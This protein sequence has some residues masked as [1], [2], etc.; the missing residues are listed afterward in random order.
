MDV[1]AN[2]GRSAASRQSTAA[3]STMYRVRHGSDG[4]RLAMTRPVHGKLRPRAESR[5]S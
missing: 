5:N 1:D 2:V 3:P 4:P